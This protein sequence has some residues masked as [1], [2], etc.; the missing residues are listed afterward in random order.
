M[1]RIASAGLVAVTA[2]LAL[3][4]PAAPSSA[5]AS[6]STPGDPIVQV[7]R[8]AVA[9]VDTLLCEATGNAVLCGG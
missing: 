9:A 5:A 3:V 1:R 6:P 2:G 8:T 7:V 4:G